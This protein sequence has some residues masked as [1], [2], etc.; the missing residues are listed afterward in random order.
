MG[1]DISP[2]PGDLFQERYLIDDVI[3]QGGF[4][5]VYRATDQASGHVVALKVLVSKADA[6]LAERFLREAQVLRALDENHIIKL[7][8]HGSTPDGLLY[9]AFEYVEGKSLFETL[10]DHGRMEPERVANI[11]QQ[12]LQALQAAHAQGILHRDI[13]PNNI[14]LQGGQDFVKVL[15]FGIAKAFGEELKPGEDLTAAGTLIGTPRYMS[16]EQIRGQTM[17]PP[18]DIY[19]LG[20]VAI[21]LLTGRKSLTGK[22]RM[23]ILQ[24]QLSH[25]PNLLPTE[26]HVP[27][28]LR[29]IV[30]QMTA[31]DTRIRYSSAAAVLR[32]LIHWNHNIADVDATM[33]ANPSDVSVQRPVVTEDA[34]STVMHRI[35]TH[36]LP[37]SPI[38]RQMPQPNPTP[39]N[40]FAGQPPPTSQNFSAPQTD[41]ASNPWAPQPVNAST[42]GTWQAS[43]SGSFPQA[44]SSSGS[45]P[46][47]ASSGSWPQPSSSGN[48]PQPN[49]STN[50]ATSG[51]LVL[52]GPQKAI[53]IVS[54][55]VPGVAHLA[56][57]QTKKGILLLVIFFLTLGAAIVVSLAFVFDAFLVL[58]AKRTREVGDFE[59]FPGYKEFFS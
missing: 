35:Q 30:E 46:N 3:G 40:S 38:P 39:P 53:L 27:G 21:E 2:N 12:I 36:D 7:F 41:Q 48:W 19:A 4:S 5:K 10:R 57:G 23:E 49:Q 26:L 24:Q 52:T 37:T 44:S 29:D 50:L 15:D 6:S 43:A 58:R 34:E 11:L 9:M 17:G 1:A 18:S 8:D 59:F 32:D 47:S 54:F 22:D 14:M 51:P 20:M 45:W 13:K 33:L 42:S 56:F 25:T 16:P 31:K 55:F 28:K